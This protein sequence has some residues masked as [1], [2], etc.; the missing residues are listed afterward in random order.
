MT[1]RGRLPF[2][3]LTPRPGTITA[4][5]GNGTVARVEVSSPPVYRLADFYRLALASGVAGFASVSYTGRKVAPL[6]EYFD[7]AVRVREST[8]TASANGRVMLAA[9]RG[10]ELSYDPATRITSVTNGGYQSLTDKM[11]AACLTGDGDVQLGYI[12]EGTWNELA[13]VSTGP[14]TSDIQSAR[15]VWLRLVRTPVAVAA[16]WG[17]GASEDALPR[18]WTCAAVS[19]SVTALTLSAGIGAARVSVEVSSGISGGFAV[20]LRDGAWLFPVDGF[21][22]PHPYGAPK[23]PSV[24]SADGSPTFAADLPYEDN[25]GVSVPAFG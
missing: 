5:T 2:H 4:E 23:S 6:R 11:V 18:Q 17:I 25:D 7:L 16:W 14:G 21:N 8:S 13:S 12:E 3:I 9:G 24:A 19:S 22:G 10:I 1:I 15:G 20:D